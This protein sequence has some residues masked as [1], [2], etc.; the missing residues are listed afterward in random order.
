MVPSD[1]LISSSDNYCFALE[2]EIYAVYLL[3][4]GTIQLSLENTNSEF[5]VKWYN[6]RSGGDLISGDQEIVTGGKWVQL[7]PPPEDQEK[8]W[9]L[10]IKK[11]D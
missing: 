7:G 11:K 10:L 4:G 2:G 3:K 8:D 9:V 6:P 1:H 5:D